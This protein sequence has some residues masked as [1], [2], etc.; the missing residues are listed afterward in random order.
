MFLDIFDN[1]ISFLESAT[2]GFISPERSFVIFIAFIFILWLLGMMFAI[3][4][5][6]NESM[7]KATN[8]KAEKAKRIARLKKKKLEEKGKQ[9]KIKKVLKDGV[10]LELGD[11]KIGILSFDLYF[12]DLYNN[13]SVEV[14]DDDYAK[15]KGKKTTIKAMKY[16]MSEK[17]RQG[18]TLKLHEVNSLSDDDLEDLK[19]ILQE[20]EEKS[21]ENLV[22]VQNYELDEYICGY[23]Y[24]GDNADTVIKVIYDVEYD[25][26]IQKPENFDLCCR[27]ETNGGWLDF[28]PSRETYLNIPLFELSPP[29]AD[30]IIERRLLI[31]GF[32]LDGSE[33]IGLDRFELEDQSSAAY[34]RL[35]GIPFIDRAQKTFLNVKYVSKKA[36]VDPELIDVERDAIRYAP[37]KVAINAPKEKNEPT[38]SGSGFIISKG[39]L[40]ATNYHVVH[41]AS[42]IEVR[43]PNIEEKFIAKVLT[44]DLSNDIALLKLQKKIKTSHFKRDIPYT[45][46]KGL[47]IK[48]G[49]DVY[50][51]G[52]PLGNIMGEKP[53]LSSGTINSPYGINEDPRHFQ[54][55]NPIQSGNS[56][57]PVFNN[58]GELTGIIVS[59]ISDQLVTEV[60][61][62]IPQNVNFAIKISY[63]ENLIEEKYSDLIGGENHLKDLSLED[64]VTLLEQFIC[65]VVTYS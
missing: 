44:K 39:G 32:D 53:R 34:N 47:K 27:R 7:K 20:I 46:N 59:S 2:N 51:V 16:F 58:K 5:R 18:D 43:F 61:G 35:S 19:T 52:Y 63:I 60:T 3:V 9:A 13:Y 4:V 26:D 31:S 33:H 49:Q 37:D 6:W 30:L 54:L 11:G 45:I 17:H 38:G 64:Q 10:I 22:K 25:P 41:P 40:I 57:G 14:T 48:T 28:Q 56:G 24:P 55:S 42:K 12:K 36:G 1:I 23:L 29:G 62:S 65:Q 21:H 50:T 15:G 8:R